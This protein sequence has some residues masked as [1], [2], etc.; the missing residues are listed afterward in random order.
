M[1]AFKSVKPKT[2]S[3]SAAENHRAIDAQT[4]AF[5]VSG[6]E[7]KCVP[8]GVTGYIPGGAKKNSAQAKAR[9]PRN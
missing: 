1:E 7:I 9:G 5:L 2:K 8:S 3:A 6:G 4:A